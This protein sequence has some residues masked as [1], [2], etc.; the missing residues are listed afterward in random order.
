MDAAMDDVEPAGIQA[1]LHLDPA[2][3]ER[4]HLPPGHHAVLLGGEKRQPSINR[5]I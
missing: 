4:Q 1:T 2:D 5:L 3:P